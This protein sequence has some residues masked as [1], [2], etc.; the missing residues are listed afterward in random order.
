MYTREDIIKARKKRIKKTDIKFKQPIGLIDSFRHTRNDKGIFYKLYNGFK[1]RNSRRC[2]VIIDGVD[3]FSPKLAKKL[4][5]KK[6]EEFTF[7]VKK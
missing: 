2:S 3:I 5:S 6:V 1:Y 7:Y 4:G